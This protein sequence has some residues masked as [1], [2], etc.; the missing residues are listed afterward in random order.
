MDTQISK[1]WKVVIAVVVA[2]LAFPLWALS[3]S[4]LKFF[5]DKCWANSTD[6]K[7]PANLLKIA[8]TYHWTYRSGEAE[9]IWRLWLLHYGGD[10]SDKTP[11][12]IYISWQEMNGTGMRKWDDGN[13]RPEQKGAD[14]CKDPHPLTPR[15]LLNIALLLELNRHYPEAKH[16]VDILQAE[17]NNLKVDIDIKTECEAF[18]IRNKTRSF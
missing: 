5:E 11:D 10:E 16:I 6:D 2:I 4:G 17:N 1:K 7:T 8:Q 18:Q 3:N 15:V 12:K 9:R 13:P 14:W